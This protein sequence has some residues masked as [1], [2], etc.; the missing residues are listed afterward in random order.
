MDDSLALYRAAPP[1]DTGSPPRPLRLHIS[2]GGSRAGGLPLLRLREP[3][4]SAGCGLSQRRPRRRG[5]RSP[6][7]RPGPFRAARGPRKGPRPSSEPSQGLWLNGEA[8]ATAP[9]TPKRIHRR[10]P[11]G[12][13]E[14][15]AAAGPLW[16]QTYVTQRA[17]S[18]KRVNRHMTSTQHSAGRSSC[19]AQ[20]F[21]SPVATQPC[22]SLISGGAGGCV[23][24]GAR[25]LLA[26]PQAHVYLPAWP[27]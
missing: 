25:L 12:G 19:Q 20:W 3:L 8:G 2:R 22:V 4:G 23:C 5:H 15:R 16:T 13:D 6:R 21:L 1:A 24:A 27:S 7:C 26:L 9:V 11:R 17:N 10:F 14:G 18:S